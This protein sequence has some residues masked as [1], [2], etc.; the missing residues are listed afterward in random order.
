MQKTNRS[1]YLWYLLLFLILTEFSTGPRRLAAF[2]H[3]P[4]PVI[5]SLLSILIA[6]VCHEFAHAYTADRLGDPNPRLAGRVSLNPLVHLDPLGT[7]FI[8]LTGF[9]WGKPVQF[10]PYNLQHPAQDG[11]VIAA[12]GPVTN[13]LIALAAGLGWRFLPLTWHFHPLASFMITLFAVNLSLG[14]FNL[15]PVYPLDGHHI[16]RSFLNPDTRRSYDRFNRS[17]GILVAYIIILPLFGGTSLA[18][19]LITPAISFASKLILGI[20]I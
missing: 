15:L 19:Y 16:V 5:F 11:A 7:I 10:D 6:L 1:R 2:I 3:N 12:A 17:F 13:L 20:A 14:V 8:I 9:G 4:L 18:S